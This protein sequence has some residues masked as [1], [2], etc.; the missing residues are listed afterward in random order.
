MNVLWRT[1]KQSIL[2]DYTVSGTIRVNAS[3]MTDNLDNREEEKEPVALDK[4]RA[5]LEQ[6]EASQRSEP[7]M[8]V[9]QK[10][11]TDRIEKLHEGLQTAW[12]NEERVL[13][14]KLAIRCAKMLG[15]TEGLQF[16]PS[17]FVLV[18][19]FLDHFG[20]LV[21]ERIRWKSSQ[22]SDSERDGT[23]ASAPR[24]LPDDFVSADVS[25]DAKEMCR[26]WFYK[27]AC[28]RELLPRLMIELALLPCYRYLSDDE[29][30]SIMA[31]LSSIARGVAD[32]LTALYVRAYLA[33]VGVTV[34]VNATA[35][36]PTSLQDYLFTMHAYKRHEGPSGLTA[37]LA[38]ADMTEAD[39]LH[40]HAPAVHWLLAVLA[41]ECASEG[42]GEAAGRA[43][44]QVVLSAYREHSNS[45]MF[46]AGVLDAFPAAYY[47]GAC[48]AMAALIK[49]AEPSRTSTAELFGVLGRQLLASPPPAAQR[50]PLLNVAWKEVA[51]T[52]RFTS[53]VP[54]AAAWLELLMEH[55]SAREV[56]ILLADISKRVAAADAEGEMDGGAG[57]G[58]AAALPALERLVRLLVERGGEYGAA[59]LTSDHL[60]KMMDMFDGVRR[61]ELSKSLLEAFASRGRLS[62]A[63][64]VHTLF[65]VGRTLHN[66]I[67]SLSP[68]S[69]RAHVSRLICDVI[70]R[71]DFGRDLE[72]ALNVYVECRGAFS[73]LELVAARLV[74]AVALLAMTAHRVVRGKHNKKTAAFVKACLAFCHITVPSIDSPVLQLRLLLLCGNVA[75]VNQCLPQTDTFFKAAISLLAELPPTEE[76]DGKRVSAEPRLLA[77][78]R[79]FASALLVVP[80]HPE[81]GPFYL[82]R[83]LLNAAQRF[84]WVEGSAAK[85][86]LYISL[87]P[88]LTAFAQR[89]LPYGC[90]G[91][92]SNDALYGGAASYMAELQQTLETLLQDVVAQLTALGESD[93]VGAKGQQSALVLELVE[94]LLVCTRLNA[95]VVALVTRLM[96]LSARNKGVSTTAAHFKAV[97]AAVRRK[98]QPQSASGTAVDSEQLLGYQAVARAM[99]AYE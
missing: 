43:V 51:R 16:Y 12:G 18:S 64:T 95:S 34:G 4:A 50:L 96:E 57:R 62:D 45:S 52:P 25:V 97:V 74:Q 28:I 14:L 38:K 13:S 58:T 39:Y 94:Q 55:Y 41:A 71:I 8:M 70:D 60:F 27:T 29:F 78:L 36:L 83:G 81:H 65:D 17:M 56:M 11:Y 88:L 82:L 22:E 90:E 72:Q 10:E 40:L 9:S 87:L 26:N 73:N 98:A 61:K 86:R 93:A 49:Q 1:K 5:R 91:V 20:K 80:G 76:V 31:R 77:Y 32:P 92:E 2:R 15:E 21:F 19:E 24:A 75:V 7:S 68:D 63:V 37:K 53:Y 30:P 6:L 99:V 79:H 54:A 66:A 48:T 35:Y 46:L 33:H 42:P 3:F 69:E 47:S 44:F 85:T 23:P 84:P 67:D 59:I 89:R